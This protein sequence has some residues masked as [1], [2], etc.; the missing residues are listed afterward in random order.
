MAEPIDFPGSNFT[1]LAPEG[2]ADIGDLHTFRQHGG[3]ANVSCWRLTPEELEEVNQTGCVW[4]SVMSYRTFFP[5][6]VGSERTCRSVVVD[7]GSIW[8]P[9]KHGSVA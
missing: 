6:F 2:R 5:A 1:Y 7:Y 4:L 3:P 8:T 9:G